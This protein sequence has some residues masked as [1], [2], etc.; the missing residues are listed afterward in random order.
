MTSREPFEYPALFD[1]A[2]ALSIFSQRKYLLLVKCEYAML[3]LSAIVAMVSNINKS[4]NTMYA[5]ILFI[6]ACILIFRSVSKPEQDWYKGR[7][8]AESIK[9]STWRYCMRAAPFVDK[10]HVHEATA[11]FRNHLKA[12]LATNRHIGDKIP[13]DSAAN[14]QITATMNSVRNASLSDRVSIYE[15]SRIR[16][17]REWYQKKS[18]SN[19][20]A[21]RRW[22]AFGVC[23]YAVAILLATLKISFSDFNFFPIEPL[24]VVSSSLIGWTQVKKYNELASAYALTAHEIGIIQGQIREVLDEESLS[25]FVNEAELAFSRE[26][27]QWVARQIR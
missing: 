8:L 4:I 16:E 17:Q 22:M 11:E 14:D 23:T 24:I 2:S 3:I 15:K 27:T 26:H 12:V 10:S 25:D 7:A 21:S 13:P 5:G 18:V 1:A 20:R 9:T 6:S 19:T